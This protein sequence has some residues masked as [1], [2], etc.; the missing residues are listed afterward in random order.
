MSRET[1]GARG[2]RVWVVA[3]VV[4]IAATAGV[5]ALFRRPMVRAPGAVSRGEVALDLTRLESGRSGALEQQAM[6]GDPTPL[7]LPTDWNFG[8]G[9]LPQ[10]VVREPGQ[11]FRLF[12]AKLAY[13]E[14]DLT[15]KLPST[16]AL[17]AAAAAAAVE[18]TQTT[19]AGLGSADVP[20]PAL[21]A[22]AAYAEVRAAATGEEVLAMALPDAQPPTGRLWQPAEFLVAVDSAGLIGPPVLTIRSGID[23]VDR[24]LQT[25]V[26]SGWRIGARLAPGLYRITV[27]P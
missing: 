6:L 13:G 26:E 24:Y 14:A 11:R 10:T 7:F 12:S 5:L 9:V 22:R 15:L 17:P 8:Q 16:V 19:L 4:A 18:M 20:V 2:R 23:E 25:Y 3:G 27:G 21:G 1:A